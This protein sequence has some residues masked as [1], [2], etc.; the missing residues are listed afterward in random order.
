MVERNH[1]L[2]I[3]LRQDVAPKVA[4][5]PVGIAYHSVFEPRLL[6]NLFRR[7]VGR[8]RPAYEHEGVV[9]VVEVDPIDGKYTVAAQPKVGH[10]GVLP[11]VA[12]TEAFRILG[13]NLS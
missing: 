7:I 6:G 4:A 10:R 13:K 5:A 11:A 8:R 12:G 3:I 1:V 2:R 9:L